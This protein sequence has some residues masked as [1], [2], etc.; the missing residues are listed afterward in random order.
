MLGVRDRDYPEY[1]SILMEVHGLLLV[2][3]L[4]TVG[5]GLTGIVGLGFLIWWV[6]RMDRKMNADDAAIFLQG[7]RV[8][9][10]IREMRAELRR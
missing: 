2:A 10:A 8:E 1:G 4:V 3:S 6:Y 9:E 7:R 5:L